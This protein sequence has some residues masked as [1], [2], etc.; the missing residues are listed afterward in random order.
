MRQRIQ[1]V[2]ALLE[3]YEGFI[4]DQWGVLHDGHTA[5]TGAI[6]ALHMLREA[7]KG[8]V[9]LS[10][11]SRRAQDSMDNLRVL[12][13]DMA[14]FDDVVTSGEGAHQVLKAPSEHG[15]VL[16]G[17]RYVAFA[18]DSYRG[19]MEGLDFQ[20]V[21]TV[22]EADMILCQGF[23]RSCVEDYDADLAL[24]RGKNL[25]LFCT[26]PDL[27]SLTPG[28]AL[29]PCPGAIAQRY[30][31]LGG[32]VV[33]FGKPTPMVYRMCM[34]AMPSA[35]A[36]VGIGDSLVHDVKGALDY[37]LDGCLVTSG[38]HRHETTTDEAVRAL[39]ARHGIE[40]HYVLEHFAP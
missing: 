26:N 5:R 27:V 22:D 38:I 1:G 11:S 21:A 18:W 31:S 30:E 7:G 34:H 39:C 29:F 8:V 25:P 10:N 19:V 40:A 15:I 14:L 9:L 23:D 35:Q 3:A 37:G 20:E 2:E 32:Q 17:A 6:E 16:P 33:W 12:G 28:G 13:F 24:A 4:V 36:V